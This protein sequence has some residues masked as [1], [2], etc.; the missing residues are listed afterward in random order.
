MLDLIG[1]AGAVLFLYMTCIW[2]IAQRIH[3]LSIVDIAWGGGFVLLS[4]I[5]LGYVSE[6]TTR[7]IIL[8][9]LV[10]I[11][12]LRLSGYIY[13]RGRGKEEDYRY[14]DMR[15][16]WGDRVALI[17]FVRVYMFQGVILFLLSFPLFIV[18]TMDNGSSLGWLDYLG[19]TLWL[20]GFGFEA[21]SDQQ[22]YRF[23]QNP[24]NKGKVIQSGLWKYTRHPNYFGESLL[25]WGIFMLALAV[26]YGIATVYAPIALTFLL[27]KVSGVPLLEKKYMQKP[28]FR[29]YAKR[30]NQFIPWF[31]K[32]K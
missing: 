24:N 3:D 20:I 25:W 28:E 23:K 7:Q 9:I 27:L 17:S 5:G 11:W 16:R 8:T 30:T 14:Q 29:E 32:K 31:P 18:Y 21:I 1:I 22:L 13:I 26:P 2:F 6:P 12:G 19:I 4:W 15:K 10:T